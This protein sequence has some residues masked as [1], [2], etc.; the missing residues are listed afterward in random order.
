M[1]GIFEGK[2]FRVGT[3]YVETNAVVR[4]DSELQGM[5]DMLCGLQSFEAKHVDKLAWF[6]QNRVSRPTAFHVYA[7]SPTKRYPVWLLTTTNQEQAT[8]LVARLNGG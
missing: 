6:Q 3:V 8:Q 5:W 7:L 2:E 4:S 1:R